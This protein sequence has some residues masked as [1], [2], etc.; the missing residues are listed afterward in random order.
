MGAEE[1]DLKNDL[2]GPKKA[3]PIFWQGQYSQNF[4]TAGQRCGHHQMLL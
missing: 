4:S 2:A 3:A 1:S